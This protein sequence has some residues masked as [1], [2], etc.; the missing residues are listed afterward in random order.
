MSSGASG[1][2]CID[3]LLWPMP[4]PI[5]LG[6]ATHGGRACTNAPAR[7][8]IY[9]WL[10]PESAN[11]RRASAIRVRG[12][13]DGQVAPHRAESRHAPDSG[14]GSRPGSGPGS[15]HVA[16][17]RSRARSWPREIT[18]PV[19]LVIV[20]DRPLSRPQAMVSV[21]NGGRPGLPASGRAAPM[22]DADDVLR[23]AVAC[24]LA[25]LTMTIASETALAT[26]TPATP[27]PRRRRKGARMSAG[28]ECRRGT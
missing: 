12:R 1:M 28:H 7:T 16:S 17:G 13:M 24:S 15:R 4:S 8:W 9:T 19:R 25:T 27:S 3:G 21:R 26:M 23:R 5:E 18:N 20:R 2:A 11:T 14:P 22:V 6:S 10:G